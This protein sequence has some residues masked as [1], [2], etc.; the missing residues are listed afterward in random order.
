MGTFAATAII[1][2]RLSFLTKEKKLHFQ[3]SFA[4]NKRMFDVSIFRL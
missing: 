4:E 1:K 2:Y 3:F